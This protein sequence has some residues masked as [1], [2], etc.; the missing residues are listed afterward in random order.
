MREFHPFRQQTSP[1]GCPFWANSEYHVWRHW[2]DNTVRHYIE[3]IDG[4]F[5]MRVLP[6]LHDNLKKRLIKSPK[7]YIR[8]TGLL[9]ALLGIETYDALL[10]HPV[11]G[12]SWETL[13]IE[14]SHAVR[15]EHRTFFLTSKGEEMDLVLSTDR[16]RIC[17]E[18]KASAAPDITHS[19]R[20]ALHDVEPAHTW[21]IAPVDA[22]Y[23]LSPEITVTT[24]NGIFED[25]RFGEFK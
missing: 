11:A 14:K 16:T 12:S 3:L 17:I 20:T 8:D 25:P 7:I 4:A 18:C 1:D 15:S 23:P 13:V 22:T 19:M 21:I 24:L 6:P 5:I 10:G 9:H 2:S